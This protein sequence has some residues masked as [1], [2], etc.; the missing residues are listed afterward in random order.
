[1]RKQHRQLAL[2]GD[3]SSGKPGLKPLSE[4]P[5]ELIA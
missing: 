2:P 4:L 3:A 5:E 1:M